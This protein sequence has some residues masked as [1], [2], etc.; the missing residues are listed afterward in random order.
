[1]NFIKYLIKN[2]LLNENIN[3]DLYLNLKNKEFC[4]KN[5]L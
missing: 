1:M 5:F 2:R 4:P 3:I